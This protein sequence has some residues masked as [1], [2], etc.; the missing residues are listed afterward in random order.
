VIVSLKQTS[1][2]PGRAVN[3]PNPALMA[4]HH[5]PD[6]YDF[7]GFDFGLTTSLT[8]GSGQPVHSYAQGPIE[9]IGTN[10]VYEIYLQC[11]DYGARTKVLVLNPEPGHTDDLGLMWA[12]RGSRNNGIASF[13]TYENETD[14]LAPNA[15]I[16]K[17]VFDLLSPAPTAASGDGFNNFEE[18]RGI[19]GIQPK[20]DALG[21]PIEDGNGNIETEFFHKRLNP[22]RLDLFVRAEGFDLD[23]A[24]GDPYRELPLDVYLPFRIG[25]AFFNAGI[26]IHNTTGWGHDATGDN[27]FFTYY[28]SGTIASIA[29][30]TVT[31][32]A[33]SG[34]D[35]AG[36]WPKHEWEFKLDCPNDVGEWTPV[37]YWDSE[38]QILYLD[39]DYELDGDNPPAFP[40]GYQIRKPLPHVNTLIVRLDNTPAVFPGEDGNIRFLAASEPNQQNLPGERFWAWSSKGYAIVNATADRNSMYGLAVGLKIPT[41][42]M[43]IQKPYVDGSGTEPPWDPL[44]DGKLSPLSEVEDRRDMGA[45]T[46]ESW[47]GDYRTFDPAGWLAATG[48]MSPFD[49]DGDGFME[50]PALS[51]PGVA[52]SSLKIETEYSLAEVWLFVVSHEIGHALG[53]PIHSDESR[54]LMNRYA[55]SWRTVD[56]LSNYYR[57]LLRVHNY[58]R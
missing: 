28:R 4:E 45:D 18:F 16:D 15:D 27:S 29:R 19:T 47:G 13:W 46:G 39:F 51:D 6:W 57:S 41:E 38:N 22:H 7:N 5:Y 50:R 34:T 53:G 24:V 54:C 37:R 11:W 32:A 31:G 48:R 14:P 58:M 33:D 8:D 21:N 10:G 56:Y 44:Y 30:Q 2:Y 42:N 43:F 49:V 40:C 12:P 3:D 55:E 35:W 23:D 17:I 1:N 9:V 36:G 26:D 25:Q 52:N 20:L